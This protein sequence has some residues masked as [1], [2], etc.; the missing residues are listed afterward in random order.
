MKL[1]LQQQESYAKSAQQQQ[2]T[3][4]AQQ[5]KNSLA[6]YKESQTNQRQNQ[7]LEAYERGQLSKDS[8]KNINKSSKA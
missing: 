6:E 8:A 3:E 4:Q 5:H 7:K 2:T 1:Q